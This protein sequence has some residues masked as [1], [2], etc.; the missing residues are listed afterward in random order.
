LGRGSKKEKKEGKK[1]RE[2]VGLSELIQNGCSF[3]LRSFFLREAKEERRRKGKERKEE[4]KGKKRRQKRFWEASE[5]IFLSRSLYFLDLS[6]AFCLALCVLGRGR[7]R[8]KKTTKKKEGR[9]QARECRL[10]GLCGA[11]EQKK[12]GPRETSTLLF[13]NDNTERLVVPQFARHSGFL[14]PW[15]DNGGER[16]RNEWKS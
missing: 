2:R 15:S 11:R 12:G 13:L 10:V 3:P 16:R 9:I 5:R 14:V 7:A 6:F 1:G 4:T 8:A